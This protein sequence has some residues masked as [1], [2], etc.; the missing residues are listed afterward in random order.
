MIRFFEIKVWFFYLSC[1]LFFFTC[2]EKI[3]FLDM[4]LNATLFLENNCFQHESFLFSLFFS[5]FIA[6]LFLY[7]TLYLC[8]FDKPVALA[9][10]INSPS[11]SMMLFNRNFFASNQ[12]KNFFVSQFQLTMWFDKTFSRQFYES[13]LIFIAPFEISTTQS[14]Q[15][16]VH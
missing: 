10:P 14:T 8:I 16:Y 15:R 3:Q 2:T 5:F 13:E 6:T 4:I 12:R 11:T 9:M 1:R 7:L